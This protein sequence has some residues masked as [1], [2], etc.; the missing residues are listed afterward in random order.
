MTFSVGTKG[1]IAG[2]APN[3]TTTT[4]GVVIPDT[5]PT[6]SGT[7]CVAREGGFKNAMSTGAQVLVQ[8]PDG[9]QR[10]CVFGDGSTFANPIL[11]PVN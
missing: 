9:S 1:A 10:W 3:N 6:N 2:M 5:A 11:Y 4:R 8:M 7:T